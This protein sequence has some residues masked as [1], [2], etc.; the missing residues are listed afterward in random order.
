MIREKIRIKQKR[1][2][3]K[4]FNESLNNVVSLTSE[5]FLVQLSSRAE[6][7][8]SDWSLLRST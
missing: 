7:R 8:L 1:K 6:S 2:S 3:N 5:K 4:L